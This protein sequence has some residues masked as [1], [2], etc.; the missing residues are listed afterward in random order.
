MLCCH[1]E[2]K[3]WGNSS[4]C[5]PQT[6]NY[7]MY[8]QG[9]KE[10]EESGMYYQGMK[11]DEKPRRKKDVAVEAGVGVSIHK[12]LDA[13]VIGVIYKSNRLIIVKLGYE[14][15]VINCLLY[16]SPSPRDYAASRMPSS[17]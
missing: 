8:Y 12:D 4:K 6:G 11:E 10:D 7:R 14:G 17:A 15:R 16:T 1:Q 13:Y 3:Q 2:T 9:M 5:V